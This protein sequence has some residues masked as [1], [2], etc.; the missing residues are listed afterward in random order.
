MTSCDYSSYLGKGRR[1]TEW[2]VMCEQ[3]VPGS[4]SNFSPGS[5]LKESV[6]CEGAFSWCR[7]HLSGNNSAPTW[8]IH[9]H[10]RSKTWWENFWFTR[11]DKHCTIPLQSKNQTNTVFTSAL[12]I[13]I[14]L[15]QGEPG[16]FHSMLCCSV[17]QSYWKTQLSFPVWLFTH[18]PFSL[19]HCK[20]PMRLARFFSSLQTLSS[21]PVFHINQP[22]NLSVDIQFFSN[23]S[24]S[25]TKFI[26]HQKSHP[27]SVFIRWD[28]QVGCQN[29]LCPFLQKPI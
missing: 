12:D 13:S 4:W 27:F 3:G 19:S 18:S 16:D 5:S 11:W 24:G 7:I 17:L 22:Y 14:F 8:R 20:I 25:K 28:I 26:P 10:R 23:H 6:V 15:G 1:H 21:S 2:D 29:L 9:C